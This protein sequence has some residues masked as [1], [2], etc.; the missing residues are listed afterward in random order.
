MANPNPKPPPKEHQFKKGQNRH[1]D[2]QPRKGKRIS[3]WL[4]ELLE[5]SRAEWPDP[6]NLPV[7]A[8]IAMALIKRALRDDGCR[9]TE[10]ILDRTEGKVAQDFNVRAAPTMTPEQ[11]AEQVRNAGLLD[12]GL[13]KDEF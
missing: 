2:A 7:A 3:T 8:L 12:G 10:I 1:P 9:A 5:K 13:G 4:F 6:T 11:V